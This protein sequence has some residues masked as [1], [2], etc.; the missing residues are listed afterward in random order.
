MYQSRHKCKIFSMKVAHASK[1]LSFP[2][3][4]LS[5]QVM[6][7][8]QWN[9]SKSICLHFWLT[10]RCL[11]QFSS[12]LLM[13]LHLMKWKALIQ[14]AAFR[15]RH[16]GGLISVPLW[17]CE[18]TAALI[19]HWLT[20]QQLKNDTLIFCLIWDDYIIPVMVL[21]SMRWLAFKR[22]QSVKLKQTSP[23]LQRQPSNS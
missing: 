16:E 18:P 7:H 6:G 21:V 2:Q 3:L 9:K 19:V 4:E 10:F 17:C 12:M 22:K 15:Q 23:H 11:L 5:L 13:S 20:G 8:L 14:G 1:S